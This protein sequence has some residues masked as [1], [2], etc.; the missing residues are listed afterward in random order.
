MTK[1]TAI[2]EGLRNRIE[3]TRNWVK[4]H[5][6]KELTGVT[7]RK[8]P[9]RLKVIKFLNDERAEAQ[10][11]RFRLFFGK[12]TMQ[13]FTDLDVRI[14]PNWVMA[15]GK[16]DTAPYIVVYALD[17]KGAGDSLRHFYFTEPARLE[18]KLETGE[19]YLSFI[20]RSIRPGAD[21]KIM[22]HRSN[23]VET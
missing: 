9:A 2:E 7:F 10:G 17:K 19:W 15:E 16:D 18:E 3:R 23:A 4:L 12:E 14:N 22:I 20:N 1:R 11:V 21:G 13:F 5:Q 8:M 6:S